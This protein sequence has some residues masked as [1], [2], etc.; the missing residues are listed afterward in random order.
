M[1]GLQLW[2]PTFFILAFAFCYVFAFHSPSFKNVPVAVVGQSSVMQPVA[3]QIQSASKGAVKVSV[4]ESLS[5]AKSEVRRG[6]IA[7]AYVPE[8]GKA[9]LVVASAN[10]FQLSSLAREFFQPVA[11]ASNAVLT[12][13][14][15][16]PLPTRDS[17]GTSLFYLTLLCTIAGYM[18]AMFVGM[19]GGGLKHWQRFSIFGATSIVFPFIA[20]LLARFVIQVV[21]G[22]FWSMW[23]IGAATS[24]AVG[25]IVNGLAYFFGRFVTAAALLLFVFA[26]VPSSGGA[27]PP[28]LVPQPFRFLHDF[29]TGTAT[30]NLLRRDVYGVGPDAWHGWLLL[31]CYAAVGIALALVGKPYFVAKARRNRAR[32]HRSMMIT[33]QVANMAHAG[34]VTPIAA[35]PS[36]LAPQLGTTVDREP[37]RALTAPHADGP[38]HTTATDVAGTEANAGMVF[39]AT[40]IS[41]SGPV[42]LTVSMHGPSDP[43]HHRR[44]RHGNHAAAHAQR[45]GERENEF[46][47][48]E[49]DGDAVAAETGALG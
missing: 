2:L 14:D 6:D 39:T 21:D 33:A 41:E 13:D 34:Y 1:I 48:E 25:C 46:S 40:A 27:Y 12:T 10:S 47:P 9:T 18:A 3:Q 28:E 11:A 16:A 37:E 24:F 49:A 44:G 5:D 35:V 17:F 38:A 15:V 23:A 8:Q 45:D 42:E 29:V 4:I 20:M 32:G 36:D 19:M 31:A 7:A 26:N 43:A 22:H 30:I